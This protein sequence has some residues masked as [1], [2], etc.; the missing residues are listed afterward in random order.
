ME[1]LELLERRVA[2][3][4]QELRTLRE[5]NGQLH[6]S[7]GLITQMREENRLL[8][9]ELKKERLLRD[10]ID[11]RIEAL[12]AGMGANEGDPAA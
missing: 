2:G 10:E 12:L 3:L 8:S 11:R 6:A 5:E 1:L 4:L 9:E 7:T